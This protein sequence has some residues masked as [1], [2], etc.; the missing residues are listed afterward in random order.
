MD[1][2]H[3]VMWYKVI[4]EFKAQ[5]CILDFEQEFTY[6]FTDGYTYMYVIYVCVCIHSFHLRKHFIRS[7]V[8]AIICFLAINIFN[9]L[10]LI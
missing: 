9:I 2:K 1:K 10:Q 5:G 6:T 3:I 8:Y 4:L 7:L